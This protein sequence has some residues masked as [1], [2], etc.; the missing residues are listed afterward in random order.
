VSGSRSR[1]SPDSAAAQ[2]VGLRQRWVSYLPSILTIVVLL[3]CVVYLS[4]LSPQPRL[5][6]SGGTG[7]GADQY[8][9]VLQEL[10][11][12]SLL[13]RSK[14][15]IDT[16]AF[17]Q[18]IQERFPELGEVTVTIPLAGRRLIVTATPAQP[19]LVLGTKDGAYIVDKRGRAIMSAK[20]APSSMKDN[21]PVV[22]DRTDVDLQVGDYVLPEVSVIFIRDVHAQLVAVKFT[23]ETFVLTGA[24]HELEVTLQGESYVIKFDL[25]GEGDLQAGTY[26]AVHKRLR[27]QGIVPKQYVDVRV[28]GRA[29]YK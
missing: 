13:N 7:L 14:L 10:Q 28:P 11:Q 26:R 19:V 1:I 9:A 5:L 24:P 2:A 3:A 21:I 18:K 25:K 16:R 29:F 12:E 22:Q 6:L 23:P 8:E 27:E 4:T 20:D 17:E 15:L